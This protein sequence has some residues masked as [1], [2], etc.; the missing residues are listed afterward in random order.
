[1]TEVQGSA[2]MQVPRVN[3]PFFPR[4]LKG[5]SAMEHNYDRGQKA[6]G[7]GGEASPSF[8]YLPSYFVVVLGTDPRLSYTDMLC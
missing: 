4:E 6:T 1:M 8:P 7:V 3:N 5:K 2:D